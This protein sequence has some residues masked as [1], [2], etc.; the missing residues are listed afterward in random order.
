[1]SSVES[2]IL[3]WKVNLKPTLQSENWCQ[4]LVSSPAVTD[5][6]T[7]NLQQVL[8]GFGCVKPICVAFAQGKNEGSPL[9]TPLQS[10]TFR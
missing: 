6:I 7:A 5:H 2:E 9:S 4:K 10:S 3:R 1:M 8:G